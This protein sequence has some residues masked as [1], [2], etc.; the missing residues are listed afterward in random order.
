MR[1]L[2]QTTQSSTSSAKQFSHI[3][4]P[5]LLL[6]LGLSATELPQAEI[7]VAGGTEVNS[8]EITRCQPCEGC[9][10]GFYN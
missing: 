4:L 1:D 6:T 3:G 7:I 9:V 5:A 8:S 2:K 10:T